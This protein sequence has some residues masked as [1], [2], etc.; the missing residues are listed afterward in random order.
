MR[1][2]NERNTREQ[3]GSATAR[4]HRARRAKPTKRKAHREKIAA[5]RTSDGRPNAANATGASSRANARAA[6]VASQA[7]PSANNTRPARE[8]RVAAAGSSL[9][10]TSSAN[11]AN[12]SSTRERRFTPL[13]LLKRI[14]PEAWAVI[15][16]SIAIVVGIGLLIFIAA[17]TVTVTIT[18]AVVHHV[19]EVRAANQEFPSEVEQ[20][21]KTVESACDDV[22]LDEKWA[23][24]VLAMM[25]AESGGDTDVYSVVGCSEDI[26]Q[27]GEG[28]AGMT[29]GSENV[30]GLGEAGLA[31]WGIDPSIDVSPNTAV[32][33][34]YAGVIETKQ[35]V[36]LFEGWLGDMDL[37]DTGKIGL[38]AQGYN[39][40]FAGWFAYCQANGITSWDYDSSLAYQSIHGGGTAEHGGKVIN[41]YE[42]A[43]E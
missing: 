2:G 40:G 1:T 5:A 15:Q 12:P 37:S 13:P 39:Y 43:K 25:Q 30:I 31:A 16:P 29:A 9:Q 28:C 10:D 24:V 19:M 35:S 36:D 26:M 41:F 34:I 18:V 8:E 42:A 38:I 4:N 23:D 27:A 32:A 14:S 22:G 20:W 33:S 3:N 7:K 21:R 6:S 17:T 11:E